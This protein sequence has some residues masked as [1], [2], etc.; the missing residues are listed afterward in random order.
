[1]ASRDPLIDPEPLI[2]RVYAYVAYRIGDG[3]DAEDVTSATIERALRYRSNYDPAK[4]TP[5]SWTMGIARACVDDHLRAVYAGREP[6]LT[7]D[8][9]PRDDVEG[10]TVDRVVIADAVSRLDGRDRE[11]IAL[12]YGAD[13]S[14]KDIGRVL[15]LTTNAVD[16]ALHRCRERL[17]HDLERSG[18]LE[19]RGVRQV[20]TEPLESAA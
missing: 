12:R 1:M 10:Q 5:V 18:A 9:P 3:P 8:P 16:V 2:R 19:P 4:G 17:R 7:H 20:G 6:G 13:L 15:G 11:L 14:A